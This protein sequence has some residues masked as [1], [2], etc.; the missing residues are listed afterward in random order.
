MDVY[1]RAVRTV[2]RELRLDIYD[3]YLARASEFFG[4]AKVRL[5]AAAIAAVFYAVQDR[6]IFCGRGYLNVVRLWQVREIYETAI[7]AE[8]PY[9]LTD[10]AT[11][12]L[13][14]R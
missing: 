3:L 13:C 12:V 7:E 6:Q 11:K 14:L 5:A 4:I 8:E 2:P 10:E 1:D 9:Q